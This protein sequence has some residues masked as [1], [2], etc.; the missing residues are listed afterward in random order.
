MK[1]K[2]KKDD[3]K[4]AFKLFLP[5]PPALFMF[6]E[7]EIWISKKDIYS[8]IHQNT[9]FDYKGNKNAL[10]GRTGTFKVKRLLVIQMI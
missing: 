9:I 10:I 3:K 2:I 8:E 5:S 4:Y 6:G 7:R 1:F